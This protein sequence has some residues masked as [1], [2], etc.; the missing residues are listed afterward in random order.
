MT[1]ILPDAWKYNRN[2]TSIDVISPNS[3]T[4]IF[5]TIPNNWHILL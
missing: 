2:T 3:L 5:S 1:D 4:V